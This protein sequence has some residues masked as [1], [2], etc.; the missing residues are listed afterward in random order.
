MTAAVVA[1]FLLVYLGMLRGGLPFLP[2]DRSGVALLGAIANI[3]VVEAAARRDV[4]IG[5]R[6]H[7]RTG[8]PVV[9]VM[10]AITAGW[11]ALR[12]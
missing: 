6:R 7:A 11:F 12:A 10:L 1:I 4:A 2:L 8:I 5:W 3:I 9:L